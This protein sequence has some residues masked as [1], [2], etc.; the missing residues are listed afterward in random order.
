MGNNDR[1]THLSLLEETGMRKLT[2]QQLAVIAAVEAD[3]DIELTYEG[4]ELDTSCTMDL[5]I[6]G[7]TRKK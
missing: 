3:M 7:E 2:D 4:Q 6:L 1:Q 5:P